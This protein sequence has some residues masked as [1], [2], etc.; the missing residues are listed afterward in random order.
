MEEP[1]SMNSGA[2]G[3]GASVA[4]DSVGA[5]SAAGGIVGSGAAVGV[6]AGAQFV[7]IRLI[8]STITIKLLNLVFITH[9]LGIIQKWDDY[10]YFLFDVTSMFFSFLWT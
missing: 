5:V 7:I 6:G 1:S 10:F 4:T 2:G 3:F 8:K 9:L